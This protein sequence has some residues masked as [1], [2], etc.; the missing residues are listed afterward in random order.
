MRNIDGSRVE[1]GEALSVS[2]DGE[3]RDDTER[4]KDVVKLT[5][6]CMVTKLEEDLF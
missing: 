5:G 4:D 3:T 2:G 1:G 6:L